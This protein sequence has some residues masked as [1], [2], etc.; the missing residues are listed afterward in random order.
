MFFF[1]LLG[2]RGHAQLLLDA[3]VGQQLYVSVRAITGAGNVLESSSDGILID[4]SAPSV[5]FVR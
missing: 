2:S 5:N 1:L 4:S 3:P